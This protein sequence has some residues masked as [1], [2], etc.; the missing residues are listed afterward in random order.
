MP[1]LPREALQW[2][3]VAQNRKELFEFLAFLVVT[4]YLLLSELR[5]EEGANYATTLPSVHLFWRP[6]PC[7]VVKRMSYLSLHLAQNS[8]LEIGGNSVF[9]KGCYQFWGLVHE[10][11]KGSLRI[12]RCLKAFWLS[13]FFLINIKSNIETLPWGSR[14]L[15]NLSRSLYHRASGGNNRSFTDCSFVHPGFCFVF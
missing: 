3:F 13:F 2:N 5:R 7:T 10:G 1:I 12:M 9:I 14:P 8:K 11:K 15:Q 6:P 4:K